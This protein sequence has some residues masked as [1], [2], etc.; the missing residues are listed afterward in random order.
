M[1]SEDEWSEMSLREFQTALSSSSP[2]PGGGTAAAVALGQAAAL[3]CMV[4]DLTVGNEKW[5]D[6]WNAAEK[7]QEVAISMFSRALDLATDDSRSFDGVMM[8]YKLPK[9]SDEDKTIRKQAIREA[10]LGAAEVPLETARLALELLETLPDLATSG[11]GNAVTDV[12]VAALLA[13]AACKGALFNVDIN[14]SGMEGKTSEK[15]KEESANI[16]EKSRQLSRLCMDAVR[17][18]MNS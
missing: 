3:T 17:D 10:T 8:A 4:A 1:Q 9:E 11:N 16:L 13:S 18:R 15:Y 7:S 2:T 12:G 5:S 14:L 6:G